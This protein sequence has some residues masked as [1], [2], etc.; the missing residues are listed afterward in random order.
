VIVDAFDRPLEF[1]TDMSK[2]WSGIVAAS[3]PL[4]DQIRSLIA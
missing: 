1:D 3:Q 2:R 4:A